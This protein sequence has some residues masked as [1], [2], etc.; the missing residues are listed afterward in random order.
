M[1]LSYSS[2]TDSTVEM[3]NAASGKY[4]GKVSIAG[5][6]YMVLAHRK[7]GHTHFLHAVLADTVL[8]WLYYP[9]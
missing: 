9:R 2:T 1:A 5:S 8:V 4:A 7:S 6:G 3:G